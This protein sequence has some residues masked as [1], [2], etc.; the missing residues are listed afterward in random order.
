VSSELYSIFT[1]FKLILPKVQLFFFFFIIII[2]VACHV[3]DEIS[4]RHV[5]CKIYL[6]HHV[7][8]FHILHL[9]H[10]I[11]LDSCCKSVEIDGKVL[12]VLCF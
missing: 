4:F 6:F 10:K 11:V 3:F 8:D 7:I 5:I 2:I 1:F 12:I 9:I